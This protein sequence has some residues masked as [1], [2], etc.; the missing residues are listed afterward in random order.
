M[1][2]SRQQYWSG[3]PFPPPGDLPD[4][5]IEPLPPASPAL[6]GGFFT[7]VPPGKP[8]S[9]KHKVKP[10]KLLNYY[11]LVSLLSPSKDRLVPELVE[12]KPKWF[13]LGR[14]AVQGT[15]CSD[16]I[17]QDVNQSTLW[18]KGK[19]S[20]FCRSQEWISPE[21]GRIGDQ[22]ASTH[23]L[24]FRHSALSP[25]LFSLFLYSF[26]PCTGFQKLQVTL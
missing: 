12:D 24:M 20:G 18:I 4:A 23:L 6:A 2:F 13:Q 7:T 8:L 21:S 26:H 22:W 3:L 16:Y 19:F 1:G 9:A 15:E 14:G 10:S 5:G 25:S 17:R 11:S